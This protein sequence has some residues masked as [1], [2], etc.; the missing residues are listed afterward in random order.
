MSSPLL[1]GPNN[2]SN[3]LQNKFKLATGSTL[4]IGLD[5]WTTSTAYIV[6]DLVTY[7]QQIYS[8]LTAHTSSTYLETDMA[9]TSPKWRIVNTQTST[10]N[11]M[12]FGMDFED[13]D[14]GGWTAC[15]CAT[16]TNGL[17][18]SVG[19]GGAIF[20]STN[21][22]RAK[23]ANTT[24][25]AVV[26]SGQLDGSY[27]LNFATSG[28]GT[29]GDMYI[30]SAY[31]IP[32]AFQSTVLQ[33]KFKYKVVSGTPVMAGT[34]S[35]TYAAAIYDV[36][37]NSWMP[38]VGAFN[39]VQSS[40]VGTFTGTTQV[41]YNSTQFQIAI[42]NPIAP[43]GASSL[44]VDDFYVGPQVTATG[45]AIGDS[46]LYTPTLSTATGSITNTT[47]SAYWMQ[48]G[49]NIKI[50]GQITFS[51]ASAA[52]TT[53][54]VSLPSGFSVNDSAIASSNQIFCGIVRFGDTGVNN[55]LGVVRY[56]KSSAKIELVS[57]V[58]NTSDAGSSAD[59]A[60]QTAISNTTP[61]TY[62]SGDIIDF[63]FELPIAGWSSNSVMS[64]DTD[65]RVIAARFYRNTTQTGVNTNATSVKVNLDTIQNDPTGAVNIGSS[66]FEVKTTGWYE[67]TGSV[68]IGATN[69]VAG[70]YYQ[71]AI[72]V[73]GSLVTYG[74]TLYVAAS[75]GFRGTV[76]YKNYF[77]AGQYIELYFYGDGNNSINT[78]TISA[79]VGTTYLEVSRLSGPAVITATDTVAASYTMSAGGTNVPNNVQ[80]NL[81]S[82]Y[83]T[84]LKVHDRTGSF[85]TSTGV[86]TCPVS[87][88]FNFFAIIEFN[89]NATG[90]RYINFAQSGSI[91]RNRNIAFAASTTAASSMVLSGGCDL[92]C[93]AGDQIVISVTQSSGVTLQ[94]C[95]AG[96]RYNYLDIKRV[97][98]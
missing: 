33:V 55:Y 15:G 36:D 4:G 32:I 12:T 46:K 77:T 96:G 25:P 40:G 50:N 79:G 57:T 47:A 75:K 67:I 95:T 31:K 44:Y 2:T 23:G 76:Y 35:N 81:T 8:C 3:N 59:P 83:V 97:G 37:N 39:F 45:P 29:I 13:N 27:S 26:S 91:T 28:A 5:V 21:G 7:G 34:S 38:L 84:Y 11:L 48:V 88:I 66:R 9:G 70:S 42:Y 16:V 92:E 72:A 98:N 18:A 69:V 86:Y 43:T 87:G 71:A 14:I 22:G 63:S 54:Y 73:D 82:T 93:L 1:W 80:T 17:L 65:T 74:P 58:T 10:Q 52:F 30:S 62:N 6:N 89:A 61:F 24:S 68:A 20:S 60:I 53:L 56:V 19:S 90:T 41:P 78:L 51:A 64:A 85:N 49:Q 94:V